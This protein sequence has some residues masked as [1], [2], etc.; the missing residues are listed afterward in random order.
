MNGYLV[1]LVRPADGEE[2]TIHVVGTAWGAMT[3]M[4]NV[5]A[6]WEGDW[7]VRCISSP[8][9]IYRDLDGSRRPMGVY[10]QTGRTFDPFQIERWMLAQVGRTDLLEEPTVPARSGRWA[11]KASQ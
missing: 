4:L 5:I 1:S 2:R 3:E 8:S 9:T 11:R 7:R 6:R 10:R